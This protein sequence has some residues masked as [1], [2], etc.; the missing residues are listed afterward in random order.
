MKRQLFEIYVGTCP[1]PISFAV[2]LAAL[3][4][5]LNSDPSL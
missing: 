3:A 5:A 2:A 1:L 4:A